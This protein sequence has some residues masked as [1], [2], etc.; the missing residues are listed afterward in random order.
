MIGVRRMRLIGAAFL[1]ALV[2][3]YVCAQAGYSYVLS[4]AVALT[5]A[6]LLLAVT[7]RKRR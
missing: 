1:L 7:W 4:Q 3:T 5:L 2:S 6:G